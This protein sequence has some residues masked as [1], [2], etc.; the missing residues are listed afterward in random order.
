ME[1]YELTFPEKNIWL[2][3]NFYESKLINIISG[4]LVIKKDFDLAL[5]E[6][7]VN[8][9]VELNEGMRLRITI[10]NSNPMQYVAP[11]EKFEADKINVKGKTEQEIEN[12]KNEYISKPIDV[13]ERP[14]FSYLLI[15]RGEGVGE[16]F[17]KAHHLI[18]DAWSGSKM[19]VGLAKIYD[20]MLEGKT[21]F[22]QYPGY[23]EYIN[24]ETEYKN[25]NKFK[26][27]ESFW[28]I[29]LDG[30]NESVGIK[31]T[32]INDTKAKR[33]TVK[34]NSDLNDLILN[35]CRE[36]RLSP[37][38]IFITALAVYLERTTEKKDIIIGTPVLN[39]GNFKEKQMQGMF[40]STMPVRF[41]IDEKTTFKELC[42]ANAKETMMLFR[43]QRFPYSVTSENLKKDNGLDENAYRLM[44]SYQNARATFDK[45]EVYRMNWKF[46][47]HSQDELAI[48]VVDLNNDGVLE[49][50]YDYI[51]ELFEDEEIHLIAERIERIIVDGISNDKTIEQIDVMSEVEKNKI[52]SVFNNTK[53]KY[54]MHDTVIS[55][56]EKQVLENPD[57]V[58]IVF[59]DDKITYKELNDKADNIAD[60]LK[61]HG[62]KAQETIGII[63]D[64]SIELIAI[65]LGILKVGGIYV[66]I[67]AN[68]NENNKKHII[69]TAKIRTIISDKPE[70]NLGVDIIYNLED[71]NIDTHISYNGAPN[72][73]INI[74]F[75]SGT[76]GMPKGVQIT[77]KNIIKLVKNTNYLT[78]E[79]DDIMLQTGSFT[80]DAST[81][82]L[83]N[84]LLNGITLHLIKEELLNPID[85]E[86]YVKK[87]KAN[88]IFLT[89]A[90]F[91][92]LI[93][94]NAEMFKSVRI[95]MT[96]GEAMS[97]A[98]AMKLL[99]T[100]PNVCLKNLYGPT[101][102]SVVSTYYNVK[103]DDSII[104]I[105]KPVS[106]TT[107]YVLDSKFRV[108]PTF[109]E[110]TLYVGGD[111]VSKGYISNSKLTDEKFVPT[112]L[113][114]SKLY[115]TG[116]RVYIKPDGNIMFVGRNDNEIKIKGLRINLDEIKEK[117]NKY[118]NIY[119]NEI[120]CLKDNND[121]K[122]LALAFSSTKEE[123]VEML[124]QYIKTFLPR[125]I[126]PRK[127][128]QLG[129]IPLTANG[130]VNKTLLKEKF[131]SICQ[132]TNIDYEYTGIYL[133]LYNLFKDVLKVEDIYPSDDFFE[134]G[135]DSILGVTLIT[136]AIEKNI[137][138]TY[139]DLYKYR[140][141]KELGD[142][143]YTGNDKKHI[144]NDI[145]QYDY[146]AIHTLLNKGTDYVKGKHKDIILSGA[147][148]YLG[149]HII[150]KFIDNGKG[151]VYCLVRNLGDKNAKDRLK[152][153]LN[154]YFGNKY[155]NEIGNR[156]RVIG[157]DNE[158]NDLSI[159]PTA[160]V[161]HFIN[162]LALVKHYGDF[163][164]FYNVNVNQVEKIANFCIEQNI[165]LVQISTLSVSG[166][167]VETAKNIDAMEITK[168][169]Y[170]ERDLYLGQDLDNIY[171]YTKFLA[172]RKI[173]ELMLKQD[174]K[175]KIL[176]M[177]NLTDR[178]S[179]G[180]FQINE[181]E[182]AFSAR[183]KS[184]INIGIIPEEIKNQTIDFT[185]VDVVA[186][187]IVCLLDIKD[188]N[189]VYHLFNDNK[190]FI[191]DI[192]KELKNQDIAIR[193]GTDEEIKEAIHK[194]IANESQIDG[195]IVD[196]TKDT[197]LKYVTDV[198]V[199]NSITNEILN[200]YNFNW[201]Q[202]TNEYLLKI[203]KRIIKF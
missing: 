93:S 186:Q 91:N 24:K 118:S 11:F 100:C 5:A 2:V 94:F 4:W 61:K 165:E 49:I 52:V 155:D 182:N 129:E 164:T 197:A 16:I 55:L 14:L 134:I 138:L 117:I 106:N 177:G 167:I 174:L 75:T 112:E 166:D 125:Y 169:I 183:L 80:F 95:L 54:P 122:Y 44:L 31:N 136:K 15:D 71:I 196:V 198:E 6:Q 193:F 178:F 170:T 187:A 43:H 111:G 121:N 157:Y 56:F 173:L 30:F 145:S 8:K 9:F 113:E 72:D 88:V 105:G 172:E 10:E 13:I 146:S 153:R 65:I 188:S 199:I 137:N 63:K 135:G 132:T 110:G 34:L 86:E 20:G 141:I 26:E 109:V 25:S 46:S 144:S 131:N 194:T 1:K 69:N 180:K 18:C 116:D 79:K 85:F 163:F 90:I 126:L 99:E 152:E 37:Y 202:P 159:L 103:K 70:N 17:L 154:Y 168:K 195:I 82:E 23:T 28:R 102:N 189:I 62:I 59:K 66:P 192:V 77:N 47:G 175:A 123:D 101:E 149:I 78:L 114:K 97:K 124:K 92:Q 201:P 7:T 29:Y 158:L 42:L 161:T 147:T 48:H 53:T 39:R 184:L 40:V 162:S 64:K 119:N 150:S 190:I 50:Y 133:E 176:R 3:E 98:H 83:W 68:A 81:L 35:Y 32:I 96:G 89:T 21:E 45:E 33:Y 38:N 151:K 160:D 200:K 58:A 185:A 51:T 156:I 12:I 148:G 60:I 36:N 74:M 73:V 140:T 139:N 19:V 115:N 22:E 108:V 107:C 127:I 67:D 181:K 87:N 27:S 84:G 171:A 130:K 179:D 41:I 76:T 128:I 143:I 203:L 57:K 191:K 120:L 142:M 104:P